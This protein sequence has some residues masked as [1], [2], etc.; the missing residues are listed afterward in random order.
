MAYNKPL[1]AIDRWNAPFWD[2]AK[3]GQLVLP[4]CEDCGHRWFPPG[5]ICPAC[6]SARTGWKPASG[7]GTIWS[8]CRFHHIY[9]KGFADEVPYNVVMVELDE[10]PMFISNVT[11]TAWE[12]LRIGQK[13]RATFES[14]TD[15]V[16]LLRFEAVPD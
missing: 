3:K 5:P 6:L 4:V 9:D 2:G 8:R 16:S 10:G 12:D 1:P 7:R 15:A 14:V 11:G 13:V